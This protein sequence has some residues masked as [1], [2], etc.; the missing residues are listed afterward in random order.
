MFIYTFQKIQNGQCNNYELAFQI[1][2]NISDIVSFCYPHMLL[3][4]KIK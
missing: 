2:V 4:I 3:Y 1:D